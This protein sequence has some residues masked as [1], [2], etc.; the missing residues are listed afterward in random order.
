MDGLHHAGMAVIGGVSTGPAG[1]TAPRAGVADR[2]RAHTKELH[3]RAESA[4]VVNALVTGTVSRAAY[5]CYLRNLHAVYEALER[6]LSERCRETRWQTIATP[7]VYR[8]EAV[9]ADLD[10]LVGREWRVRCRLVTATERYRERIHAAGRGGGARLAAHAYTRYLGDLSGGRI[11][12]SV[13]ARALT[14]APEELR[15]YRFDEVDDLARFKVDYRRAFDAWDDAESDLRDEAIAAFELNI[16]LAE[17]VAA[18]A[19]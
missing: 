17:E 4:G 10:A 13:A 5:L 7:A 11:L 6:E 18:A 9:A 15:T 12:A 14:L 8:A 3:S 2:L 1:R 16:D 19:A